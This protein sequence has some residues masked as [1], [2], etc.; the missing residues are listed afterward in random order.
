MSVVSV[1]VITNPKTRESRLFTSIPEFVGRQLVSMIRMYA[2]YRPMRF[3]FYLGTVL[4][5]LGLIPI[6]RFLI[7]Y[8]SG[9]GG[10]YIQSLVLGGALLTMGFIVFVSGLLSDLISQ[11][12]QLSEI[13]LEKVRELEL[14]SPRDQ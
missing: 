13:A 3:F 5:V 14:R 2:M 7:F 11:N 12:R 8:F 6:V 4:T 10:G 1:P 9:D